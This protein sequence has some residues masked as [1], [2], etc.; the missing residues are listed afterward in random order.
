MPSDDFLLEISLDALRAGVPADDMPTRVVM[1]A[2][3]PDRLKDAGELKL[4]SRL[5]RVS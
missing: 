4:C 1:P 2:T 3:T 5:L